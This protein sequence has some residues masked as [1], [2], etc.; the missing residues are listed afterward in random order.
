VVYPALSGRHQLRLG[1]C[2]RQASAKANQMQRHAWAVEG[3]TERPS[4]NQATA[5]Q[6][7]H[8][9]REAIGLTPDV[10]PA[11]RLIRTA[12]VSD[13]ISARFRW[14]IYVLTRR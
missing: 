5:A 12:A 7:R 14:I 10:L 9:Q 3:P 8:R 6:I 13:R 1:A 4:V 2:R 11:D